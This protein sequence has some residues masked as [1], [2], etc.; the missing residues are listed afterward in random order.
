MRNSAHNLLL[1]IGIVVAAVLSTP[2]YAGERDVPQLPVTVTHT[3]QLNAQILEGI[4]GQGEQSETPSA[5]HMELAVILW[6][7]SGHGEGGGKTVQVNNTG[8]NN[9]QTQTLTLYR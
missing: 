6:D 9:V 8:T 1:A 3:P 5:P 4:R 7:E 2:A